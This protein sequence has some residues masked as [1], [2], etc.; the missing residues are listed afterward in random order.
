MDFELLLFDRIEKIKQIN[1]Q[2]DLEHNSYIAFS[3]G[4][5]STVLHYLIDLALPNNKIPRLFMNTGME[6]INM[7]KFVKNMAKTDDRIIILNSGVKI[8]KMLN[9]YGYPFKSKQHAHNVAIYQHSGITKT[10]ISYLGLD[11][12]KS[13]Y[14]CPKQLKYQFSD[15]FNLK[16]SEKCCYKLKKEPQ[17][18][19]AKENNKSIVLTGM[20]KSEGGNRN[21]L[22]CISSN[23]AK[24]HFLAPVNDDF[25]EW[26]IKKYNIR[27]CKLYYPPYNFKRTGCKGCPFALDLQNELDA[28]KKLLP[29]EYKQCCFLWKPVYDEYI[30]IDYRLEKPSR[31]LSIFDLEDLQE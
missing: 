2:Y 16:I 3:G 30:R 15:N 9:E 10:N 14:R 27:L 22:T 28:I 1:E 7:V 31:Q 13:I 21:N 29:N 4:K 23:G 11:N 6:Y 12:T 18:K 19:W 17:H 5:D 25:M 20:R 24:I 8:K 26:F